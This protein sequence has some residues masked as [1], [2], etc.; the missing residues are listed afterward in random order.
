MEARG[1]E[2]AETVP[3]SRKLQ[4]ADALNLLEKASRVSVAKGRKLTEFSGDNIVSD[5]AATAM[6]GTTGNLRAPT[7]VVGATLL[8]GFNEALYSEVF[9]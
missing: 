8:V 9:G 5:E 2:V 4:R 1:I 3:A 7:L 6:L